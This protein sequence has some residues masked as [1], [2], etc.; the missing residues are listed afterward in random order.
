[1]R[2]FSVFSRLEGLR[3]I[4]SPQ[5]KVRGKVSLRQGSVHKRTLT[6]T[7]STKDCEPLPDL[8]VICVT[9]EYMVLCSS[10]EAVAMDSVSAASFVFECGRGEVEAMA[11]LS[12]A[13]CS[14]VTLPWVKNHWS[15]VVWK[16]ASLAR[17]RPD[18]RATYWH[19][20]AAVDQLKYRCALSYHSLPFV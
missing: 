9:D 6:S 18:V 1:M 12:A 11:A 5:R 16:L 13:G 17:T 14:L 10:E 20:Q 2:L 4:A 19:W 3:R 8:I 15:L 7:W